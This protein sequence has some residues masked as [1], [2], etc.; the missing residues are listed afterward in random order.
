[1]IDVA[2]VV[3][4]DELVVGPDFLELAVGVQ[5]RRVVP[6]ADILDGRVIAP[7]VCQGEVLVRGEFPVFDSSS[8]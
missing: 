2:V 6:E 7:D 4:V 8:P 5:K 1:M 3:H